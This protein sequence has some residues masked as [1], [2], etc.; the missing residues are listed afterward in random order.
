[1]I[2]KEIENNFTYHPPTP[3]QVKLYQEVRD[4]FKDL[5]LFINQ[6]CPQGREL[7]CAL[8]NLEQSNFWA[9]AAIARKPKERD[10]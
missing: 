1:M 5:A 10:T 2:P 8:T 3:D 4:R 9:N 7:P 6:V